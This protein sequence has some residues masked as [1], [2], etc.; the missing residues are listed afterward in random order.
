[1][2]AR[3]Y[4]DGRAPPAVVAVLERRLPQ[5][6]L[7]VS[8]LEAVTSISS[9]Y[10]FVQGPPGSGKTWQG[11]RMAVELMRLGKRV[12]V[13]SLS[14]KAIHKLLEEIEREAREQ[15]FRFHGRKKSTAGNPE[16]RFEGA[17]VDSSD[18]WQDM[19]EP[20]LQLVAGTAWLFAR[21]QFEGHVHTLFVD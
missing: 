5:A 19:L 4:L 7:D 12:G 14:H 15:G 21:E 3:A 9:S 2:L 16:S 18:G 11:A 6:R 8:P 10:L 20:E 1:R 13:T 17:F